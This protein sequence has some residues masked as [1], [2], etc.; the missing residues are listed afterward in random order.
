VN[1]LF[2]SPFFAPEIISTGKYNTYLARGL[3]AE[4][5]GVTVVCSDP[6]YPDWSPRPS[7]HSETDMRILRGGSKVH[8]PKSTVGRRLVL[9]GWYV[10]HV[11]K[12]LVGSRIRPD[13]AIAVFPPVSFAFVL[14]ILVKPDTPIYGIV[15][16]LLGIMATSSGGRWRRLISRVMG[17]I[18][19]KAMSRCTRLVALS[20]SMKTVLTDRYGVAPEKIVVAYPF[21]TLKE[22]KHTQTELADLLP[23]NVINVVYSGALGEKQRPE[24]LYSL[25]KRLS[26]GNLNLRCHVFSGGPAF[27]ALKERAMQDGAQSVRFHDLVPERNL[28]E[29]YERSNIQVIP[30]ATGTG[31]GAFPSKLPNLVAA[32]VPVLAICDVDSE[33]ARVVEASGIGRVVSTWDESSLVSEAVA[34]VNDVKGKSRE[35]RREKMAAFVRVNFEV[36]S[37]VEKLD[38]ATPDVR[39]SLEIDSESG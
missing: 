12:S 31:A 29:L 20:D 8:Y 16:D 14:P 25:F 10:W 13:A 23:N 28:W 38:L 19:R 15:H 7:K 2:L 18:E 21:A 36:S 4:G 33:L 22:L 30:Q 37:L 11:I 26:A 1:V 35:Q 32:G 9:E 3:V 5:H 6:L 34:F 17:L 24:Q 27:E 39:S